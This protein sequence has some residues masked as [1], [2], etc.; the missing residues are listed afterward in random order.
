MLHLLPLQV[1]TF[2]GEQVLKIK[3]KNIRRH[4]MGGHGVL[5]QGWGWEWSRLG[6]DAIEAEGPMCVKSYGTS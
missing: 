2:P 5:W 3:C 1:S 6:G 4:F